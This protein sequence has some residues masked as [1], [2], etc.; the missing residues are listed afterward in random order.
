ML[1]DYHRAHTNPLSFYVAFYEY[2]KKAGDF[3]HSPRLCLPGVGWFIEESR[4]RNLKA[5]SSEGKTEQSLK[6][7]EM[8]IQQNDQKQLVYFWYQ[9]R[10]RN[11]TNEFSAKFFMVWD[12][13]WHR[14]TDGALVRL[15]TPIS[16]D[17]PLP[18]SRGIMDHFAL[19]VS[20]ELERY[21][22]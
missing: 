10:G 17:Q 12:G 21:L 14:R 11:F 5:S 19:L 13:L 7:N 20:E 2:Q 22:P 9:G 6:L 4:V 16:P 3:V 1:I 18:E 8:V 15:I